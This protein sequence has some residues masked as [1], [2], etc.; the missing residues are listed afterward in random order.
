MRSREKKKKKKKGVQRSS[1]LLAH[2]HITRVFH[3][4]FLA[5]NITRVIDYLLWYRYR[6]LLTL[7]LTLTLYCTVLY[8]TVLYS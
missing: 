7:T 6:S 5:P 4:I 3:F 2:Q 1:S 8:C